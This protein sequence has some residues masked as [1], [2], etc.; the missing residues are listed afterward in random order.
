MGRLGQFKDLAGQRFGRLTVM[1]LDHTTERTYIDKRNGNI[2]KQIVRYWFCMCD[3]GGTKVI[4]GTHAV[5]SPKWGTRSCGCLSK[6]IHK[7]ALWH[8]K[9]R[10][11]GTAF[12][13]CLSQYKSNAKNKGRAW[14]LTD[15]QFRKLTSSPCHYTGKMPST[16]KTARSG[17]VYIYNGIDRV[18]SNIGYTLENCVPCCA[19]VNRMKMDLSKEEFIE[20]CREISKRF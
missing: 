7:S 1:M 3:C 14:D 12:R 8:I 19:A 9:S 2:Q 20:L 16:K 17:E 18:D 10:R 11:E 15:E 4:R 13:L 5:G 6:E